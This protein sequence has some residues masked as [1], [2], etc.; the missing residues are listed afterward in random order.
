MPPD[1]ARAIR[2]QVRQGHALLKNPPLLG[3]FSSVDEITGEIEK[4]RGINDRLKTLDKDVERQL[5]GQ[6]SR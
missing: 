6:Q 1:R 4:V 5:A 2:E 3:A